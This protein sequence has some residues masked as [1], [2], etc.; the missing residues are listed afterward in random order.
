MA[1][2]R[3][4]SVS[5]ETVMTQAHATPGGAVAGTINLTGGSKSRRIDAVNVALAARIE[6]EGRDRE[7]ATILPFQQQRLY[8]AFEL[9]PGAR[10]ALP[11]SIP[12]PWEAPLTVAGQV[13]LHG[14]FVGVQTEVEIARATDKGD[15]DQIFIHPLPAQDNI[16]AALA[17][18]GFRFKGADL[19]RG[20]LR[21]STMPFYQEIEYFA[22]PEYARFMTELEVTFL[23]GPA[24]MDVVLEADNRGSLFVQGG[25]T[26]AR[27]RV[28][29]A[30]AASIDWQG[31]IRHHLGVMAA[32][33]GW[34]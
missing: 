5:V 24:G 13:Q 32:K 9:P 28:D 2:N 10:H 21:G 25:D 3:A 20:T 17:H 19:E 7:F 22:S 11:F 12:L 33:R 4:G 15:L 8:G 30:S 18:L 14:M 16:L 26:Y 27:F 31:Q 1:F 29:Y 6:I 23:S 34:R